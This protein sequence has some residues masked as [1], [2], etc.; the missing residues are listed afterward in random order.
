M[1]VRKLVGSRDGSV[2]KRLLKEGKDVLGKLNVIVASAVRV[3]KSCS[4][5]R[6]RAFLYRRHS[7]GTVL[8]RSVS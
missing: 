8:V 6:P 5:L 3:A 2:V 7:Q 4:D 1:F